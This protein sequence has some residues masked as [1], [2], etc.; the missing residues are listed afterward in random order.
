MKGVVPNVLVLGWPVYQALRKHP[1]VI[2]RIKYTS[3]P[4][5]KDI[6][7]AMLGHDGCCD[8]PETGTGT[9]GQS[10]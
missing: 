4:D 10:R 6:T 5:A 9:A 2:D 8:V 7:P 1:L 3:Q